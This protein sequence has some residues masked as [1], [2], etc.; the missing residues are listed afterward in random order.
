MNDLVLID[1][2]K[3]PV[4]IG[5]EPGERTLPQILEL[6]LSISVAGSKC[7][8]SGNP[9]DTVCYRTV[10]EELKE[11]AN[12]NEWPLLEQLA[13]DATKLIFE[14]FVAAIQV[15]LEIRKFVIP[16]TEWVGIKISRHREVR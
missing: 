3:L 16:N 14:R 10:C 15:E 4:R 7:L 2:L 1:G 12:K 11:L 5:C 13:E 6:N 9:N 8:N